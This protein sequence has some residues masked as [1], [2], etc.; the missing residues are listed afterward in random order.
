MYK[1]VVT[2]EKGG[3]GKST[4]T[5]LLIEYLNFLGKKVQLVDTDPLQISQTYALNC[6][7]EGRQVSFIQA[8][9]QVIDTA[10]SSGSALA[11]IRQANLI[12]VPFRPHYA[13]L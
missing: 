3:T 4:I 12:I 1:I 6:Q 2:N 10:G 13:D 9:Y 11:W 5:A 7:S 8:D